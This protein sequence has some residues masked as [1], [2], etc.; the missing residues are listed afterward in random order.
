MQ[1]KITNLYSDET[2][3]YDGTDEE[4]LAKLKARYD[5]AKGETLPEIIQHLS[6]AQAYGVEVTQGPPK[7]PELEKTTGEGRLHRLKM[8]WPVGAEHNER[9]KVQ[10]RDL[11][12]R[13]KT[14][15]SWVSARSGLVQSQDGHPVSALE[16]NAKNE[17][18]D[19]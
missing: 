13:A 11:V 18:D 5:W 12:T 16:P 19:V 7:D 17:K 3:T 9:I 6:R 15:V 2:A 4:V 14:D 8:I 1:V 10:H